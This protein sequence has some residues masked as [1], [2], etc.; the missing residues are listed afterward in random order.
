MGLASDKSWPFLAASVHMPCRNGTEGY[1]IHNV[2]ATC[3]PE[4]WITLTYSFVVQLVQM[5]GGHLMQHSYVTQLVMRSTHTILIDGI[6]TSFYYFSI[7]IILYGISI[8]NIQTLRLV[9]R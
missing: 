3:A 1:N 4:G 9:Y 5:R 6:A 2:I 7:H 8:Y